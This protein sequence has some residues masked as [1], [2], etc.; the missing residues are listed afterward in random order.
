MESISVMYGNS[1]LSSCSVGQESL[2]C[3]R[4]RNVLY[5]LRQQ[6]KVLYNK[7]VCCI[8]G[9]IRILMAFLG[10]LFR[11]FFILFLF[12]VFNQTGNHIP[13]LK[14]HVLVILKFL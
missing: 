11:Y 7:M 3:L 14:S 10:S 8:L 6:P 5:N 9:Y 2:F 1:V 12:K 13:V 4:S